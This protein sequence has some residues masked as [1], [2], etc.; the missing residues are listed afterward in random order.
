MVHIINGTA[1]TIEHVLLD[2]CSQSQIP[3]ST[4]FSFGRDGAPV[5][6]GKR[7]VVA[8]R[9]K[10]H[11]PEIISIHCAAHQVALAC[12]EAATKVDYIKKYL[13]SLH[14]LW[15]IDFYSGSGSDRLH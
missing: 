1:E 5:M 8:T 3:T 13:T 6:V 4:I 2:V 15:C 9:M 14:K 12:S 10:S 7:T 11:N